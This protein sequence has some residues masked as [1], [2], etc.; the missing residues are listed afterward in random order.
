MSCCCC[1]HTNKRE[2]GP[3]RLLYFRALCFALNEIKIDSS[4]FIQR[5]NRAGAFTLP[6]GLS[7]LADSTFYTHTLL[8]QISFEPLKVCLFWTGCLRLQLPTLL[9]KLIADV[10]KTPLVH[11]WEDTDGI[12]DVLGWPTNVFFRMPADKL[13]LY[14]IK[15]MTKPIKILRICVSYNTITLSSKLR[16]SF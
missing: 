5:E 2:L 7:L 8:G 12:N 11:D 3:E 1:P 15:T 16:C 6:Q 14:K 9:F 10:L 13:H 4:C